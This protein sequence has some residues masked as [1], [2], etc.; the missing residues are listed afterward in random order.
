MEKILS[1]YHARSS[2][3]ATGTWDENYRSY[4]GRSAG[5]VTDKKDEFPTAITHIKYTIKPG[6]FS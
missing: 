6:E 3:D 1:H 2:V 4:P 5:Y